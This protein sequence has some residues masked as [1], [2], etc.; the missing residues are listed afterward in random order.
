IDLKADSVK[1]ER[2]AYIVRNGPLSPNHSAS[3]RRTVSI[4]GRAIETMLV[5]SG[6]N[7]VLRTYFVTQRDGVDY[8]LAY[9]GTDFSS[10]KTGEFDK[11][12]MNALYEYGYRQAREN[13]EWHKMPPGLAAA[14]A[15]RKK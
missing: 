10:P 6:K 5:S 12:Y 11:A 8:N 4:A 3:D 15:A 2:R 14:A 7:D 1:R 9:I 13:R